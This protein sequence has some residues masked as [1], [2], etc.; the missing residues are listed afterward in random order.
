MEKCFTNIFKNLGLGFVDSRTR[1]PKEA[2]QEARLKIP[3]VAKLELERSKSI[4]I[5][6]IKEL[7]V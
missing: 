6:E 3:S 1:S 5:G 7:Y 2:M 4:V